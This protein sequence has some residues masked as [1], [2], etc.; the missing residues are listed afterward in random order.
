MQAHSYLR[1]RGT[2]S[3][4]LTHVSENQEDTMIPRTTNHRPMIAAMAVAALCASFA[5]EANASCLKTPLKDRLA[6]PALRVAA[7][8]AAQAQGGNDPSGA[9]TWL[10]GMWLSE[11]RVG[12]ALY[13]QT[14]QQFH[15]DGTENILSNGLPPVLG[16]V[17]LGIWTQLGSRT[18]KLR[19]LAWNWDADG[20]FAG[21][22]QMI[23]TFEVDRSGS[24]Y[25]GTFVADSYDLSNN[26]IPELHVEGTVR[27]ARLRVD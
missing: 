26:V 1:E 2:M 3:C 13:D 24:S 27:A 16:N 5:V 14:L 4:R 15:S 6:L 22:F 12:D 18:I 21:L 19:H 11:F 20:Q 8:G 23:V 7:P 17:C 9:A 25:A 10:V